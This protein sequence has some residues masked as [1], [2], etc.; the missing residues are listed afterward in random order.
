MLALSYSMEAMMVKSLSRIMVALVLTGPMFNAFAYD[1]VKT[2]GIIG[3]S[4]SSSMVRVDDTTM[5]ITTRK[6]ISGDLEEVNKPGTTMYNTLVAVQNAATVRA[7]VEA[8]ALGYLALEV[9]GSRDLSKVQ[10]M[11][12][13]SKGGTPTTDFTF[14]PGHYNNDV[15]LAIEVVVKTLPIALP[16]GQNPK[17]FDVAKVLKSFGIE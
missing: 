14:A 7:A 12:A 13:A 11:R 3:N 9:M 16:D 10:E 15:E 4:F 1:A 2:G 8:K 5:R 6:R 17:V